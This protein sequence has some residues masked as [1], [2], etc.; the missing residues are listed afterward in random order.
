MVNFV[1]DD[2]LSTETVDNTVIVQETLRRLW[3]HDLQILQ[4]IRRTYQRAP[5]RT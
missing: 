5:G 1:S 4:L 3:F 2:F